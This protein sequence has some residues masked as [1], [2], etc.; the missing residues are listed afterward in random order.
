V[1]HPTSGFDAHLSGVAVGPE[2]NV[3]VNDSGVF[4]EGPPEFNDAEP[5]TFL[6][7]SESP[8][9]VTGSSALD[10]A[11]GE[12]FVDRESSIDRYASGEESPSGLLETFPSAGGLQASQGIAVSPAGTVF[13]TERTADDVKVFGE[14]PLAQV[15]VG[16]VSG[17]RPTSVT[18]QGSVTPEGEKVS[19]CE[20]EYGTTTSYGQIAAC[21]PAAGSLGE[22]TEQKLVGATVSGLQSGT[23]YHYRLVASDASGTNASVD[24]TFTTPGPSV[25]DEQVTYVEAM[26]ATLGAQIDPDGGATSYRFEYD[27][28]PYTSSAAHGTSV[29]IPDTLIGSGTT[30]VPVSVRVTGLHPGTLYYY[31]AVAAGEPLG[32]KEAFYGLDQTFETNPG[33]AP[34]GNCPNEKQRAEQPFGL[35]LPDCRAYEMASPLE[36]GGQDAVDPQGADGIRASLNGEAIAYGS[37]GSFAGPAGAAENSE[38]LSRRAGGA[39]STRA[40]TPPQEPL[41]LTTESYKASV[42]TPEL[43]AGVAD[44]T[45]RLTNDTPK[46]VTGEDQEEKIN[47]LYVTDLTEPLSEQSY[48]FVGEVG[49]VTTFQS[50]VGASTDLSH[51]AFEGGQF[52]GGAGGGISPALEWVNG[53]VI[54]VGVAN[55]GEPVSASVG[56][57]G[58]NSY[59]REQAEA[60]HA[61]S[62]DGSRVYFTSPGTEGQSKTGQLYVRVNVGVKVEPEPE[63]EQS[64]LGPKEECIEPT[65]ACTI[66]VSASQRS[67]S[68][69]H[70]LQAARFWGA[71][72]GSK[73]PE[74]AEDGPGPERVFFTSNAELTNDA[75]TGPEDNAPNLYEYE[76]GTNPDALGRLT[77]LTGETTDK[78]GN[79]AAVQGVVQISK[80]GQYVYFVAKG[81]LAT[82]ASEQQCREETEG[83][84]TGKEPKQD[85][86]GCN[87]YV[88]HEGGKPVFVAMLAAGDA[89]DWQAAPGG[90]KDGGPANHTAVVDP[91]GA[92]LA[93]VSARS[94]TGYDNEQA[95]TGDCERQEKQTP[96]FTETGACREV[97]VYD[98]QAG[99]L[100]CASCDPTGARPVGPSNLGLIPFQLSSYRPRNFSQDGTLFF[101]SSDALAPHAKDGRQNVYE[102]EQGHVYPL[103]DVAGDNESTFLDADANGD[104][105]FFASSDKLLP[106]DTSENAEVWDARVEGGL[107]VTVAPQACTTAEACRTAS[108]P[109]PAVFGAPPSATF[110]G[111]GNITPPPPAVVTTKKKTATELKAE[112]LAKALKTCRKDKKKSKRQKCEKQA[113]SKYGAAKKAKKSSNDR[114]ASR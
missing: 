41:V 36:T 25:T 57:A 53:T 101:D 94:L 102:Y 27:T 43:T 105:V 31:R 26:A 111:P 85:N 91:S 50:P 84:R 12:L 1:G 64:K 66:E 11:T 8:V 40:I 16:A 7:S 3:W 17:L 18:L 90:N 81:A 82:G 13:A 109:T 23:S 55:D 108:P 112:K 103:S 110:S 114:R 88:S 21:E 63:R 100:V 68:D 104:N 97:Y 2:G 34:T 58:L 106:E 49:I 38:F 29:P 70:G 30:A 86:L 65:K 47:K 95:A 83:E 99:T 59:G 44:S 61:V 54:P 39:W 37:R 52:E 9:P 51:V 80:E 22:G 113:R 107:P 87:L 28:S 75:Y 32:A 72:T 14:F 19:S 35:T 74:G 77:D 10:P 69:T 4:S 98:A 76:P 71:S 45:A 48:K 42:F 78:T 46:T 24:N 89:S 5:N 60:W 67:T 6:E 33:P 73:G 62:A 15:F 93:F 96:T 20:F 56:T 79:G 92:R